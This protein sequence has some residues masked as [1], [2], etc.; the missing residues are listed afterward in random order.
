MTTRRYASASAFRQALDQRLR[1][2]AADDGEELMRRR[3]LVVF[4]RFLARVTRAHGDAV[5]LKGGYALE[6]RLERARTTKDIDIR[7]VSASD[8][9]LAGLQEAA[10]L[11]LDDFFVF[12]VRAHPDHPELDIL[13]PHGGRRFRVEPKL[14]GKPY[15]NAF[16]LDVVFGG[17]VLGDPDVISGDDVLSFAGIP[18]IELRVFPI[19]THIAEKLHAYTLPRS[20][21]NTR[22]K[23]LPD[24]ALLATIRELDAGLLRHAIAETFAL[25]TTHTIPQ[26]VPDPP[27]IAS[28][29]DWASVYARMAEQDDLR[30]RTLSE[31]LSV[32]RGF[33][34]FVLEDSAE[35]TWS[36]A[37]WSWVVRR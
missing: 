13:G 35:A 1:T 23:D 24:L 7:L 2:A 16:G 11:D 9:L 10:R 15:G 19:E 12:E 4:D 28:P 30:W 31:L 27:V 8:D 29:H 25:R 3:Q 32:V 20:R 6:L 22:V 36:P 14:I 33:M 37:E 17:S 5:M 21:P 34:G 18:P 26:T